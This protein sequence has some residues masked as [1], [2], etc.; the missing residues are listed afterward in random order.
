MEKFASLMQSAHDQYLNTEKGTQNE[1]M[2][3][4]WTSQK[5]QSQEE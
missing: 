5:S 4:D 3:V 1:K 2:E